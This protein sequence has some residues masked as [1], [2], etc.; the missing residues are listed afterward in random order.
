M[1]KQLMEVSALA[2][3]EQMISISWSAVKCTASYEVF[4]KQEQEGSVWELS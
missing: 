3:E 4:Q 1:E 2:R